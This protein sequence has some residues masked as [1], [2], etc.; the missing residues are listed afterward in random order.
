M[1]PELSY[2]LGMYIGDGMC[3]EEYIRKTNGKPKFLTSLVVKAEQ[4]ESLKQ[5]LEEHKVHYNIQ[6]RTSTKGEEYYTYFT[7][8]DIVSEYI[9][10]WVGSSGNKTLDRIPK[11]FYW[12]FLSG[13][14]DS[15]GNVDADKIHLCNTDLCIISGLKRMLDNLGVRYTVFEQKTRNRPCFWI[16]IKS[17]EV[18]HLN[19]D[20]RITHK[21][22][23]YQKLKNRSRGRKIELGEQ[24]FKDNEYIL[25][26]VLPRTTFKRRFA[27]KNW[28]LDEYEILK[29][30]KYRETEGM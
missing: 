1:T 13:F 28:V 27:N 22:E 30:N 19:L 3:R 12:E 17:S 21:K 20:L 7:R 8:D 18:I 11:E 24:W 23:R 5:V 14:I 25:E 16:N 6:V 10:K 2:W 26:A 9:V 15:D 29:V 4:V